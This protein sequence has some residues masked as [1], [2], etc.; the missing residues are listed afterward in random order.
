M[1]RTPSFTVYNSL[2]AAASSTKSHEASSTHLKTSTQVKTDL[3]RMKAAKDKEKNR[4]SEKYE[5]L[6]DTEIDALI[7]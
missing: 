5:I 1:Q 3:T 7:E 2:A 6:Y 4:V